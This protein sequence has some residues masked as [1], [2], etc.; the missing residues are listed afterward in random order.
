M[1]TELAK[2][3]APRRMMAGAVA[4]LT[5]ALAGCAGSFGANEVSTAGVREAATVREGT[6]TAVREVTIQNDNSVL[7]AATGAVLGGIA[8]AQIG[9]GD[10]ANTAGGVAGAVLG[11]VAGN[12]AGKALNRRRGFAYTVRFA[13]GELKEIVQGADIYIAPGT[14]VNVVFR[15]D[16]V[17]VTP[18]SGGA[19]AF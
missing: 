3:P 15:T 12:Q 16:G 19:P 6:V 11:G 17:V 4:G 1:S 10:A 13:S 9:G 7:G 2:R 8:G 14:P 5:L 18:S